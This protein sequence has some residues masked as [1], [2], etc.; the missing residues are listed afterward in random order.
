VYAALRPFAG[1]VAFVGVVAALG[2]PGVEGR[3]L[4]DPVGPS[5]S[6]GVPL[7]LHR[8][9]DTPR[10][11][12]SEANEVI[13]E[14]C[15]RCH[16]DRRRRGNLSLEDFDAGR[17]WASPDVAEA[18]VRKL[19]AGMMPP[20]GSRRPEEAVLQGLAATLESQL[21]SFAVANPNPGVRTFQRLNQAEY[22]N[23]IGD[24]L[25][26]RI[27]AAAYLPSDTKSANFDNIADVQLLSPTLLDAYLN[28]AAEI[29]RLA[30]GDPNAIPE[31]A[32][33]TVPR[34][35]S[36]WEWVEG[37]PFGTR[38]GLSVVHTFPADGNYTFRIRLQPTPTGQLFGR[39]ARD[40]AV[41]ISVDGER[42][43]LIPV[44]RWTSQADPTGM[45]VRVDHTV[46][47]RAGQHRVSAAFLPNFEGPVDDILAPVGHSLAD[48]RIGLA[49]GVTTLPHLRDLVISGPYDATGVSDTPT[50]RRI[51]VC[52]PTAPDEEEPCARRILTRLATRAYRR[53]LRDDDV[54]DLMAFYRDAA[55][56]D[57]FEHGVRMGLQAMLAS[58]HF[59]FRIEDGEGAPDA[60]GLV[61][62]S[63]TDLASRLSFF[64]WG[65]VPDGEL[66]ALAR[67]GRL[68]DADVLEGQV[69][70][71]L[72][73]PAAARLG[74]RFASQWL[75]LSDIEKVHP[76]PLVY[77]DFDQQLAGMMVEETERFF[78][79]LVADDASVLQLLTAD[80]TVVN[81]RLAAH[82]GIPGVAGPEFRRV[83][84]VDPRRR[85]L[86]GQGSILTLTSHANRTSPVLRGKWV[87]EVLMGT[88]PP[89]PPPDVPDLDANEPAVD[90]RFLTVR[91]QME[92][93]RADPS[94][95][96]C[97][98]FI[99]PIGLALENFD[100]VGRWRTRD[101]G[102][103]VDASGELYD[104][105]PLTGPGDLREALMARPEPLL[106]TF[107]ENLM[108]YALGRRV[109]YY[110]MPTVR[111]IVADARDRDYAIS[112]FVLGVVR[113]PAFQMRRTDDP[114]DDAADA[115]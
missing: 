55:A 49:Y 106:R 58:P 94:C 109:E 76:D 87:M 27:D 107:T 68:A 18:M 52:R 43:A 108:A 103:P 54:T 114:T 59:I 110:D 13:E 70:R 8:H 62:L 115:G 1:S 67:D 98:V 104:G 69:R 4:P 77:P 84:H 16:S 19:R 82:Y 40:E 28:G 17:A 11:P 72:A 29:A 113:S 100:V 81:E 75:R 35:A 85:G 21:D 64:L 14:T 78:N 3:S 46:H 33:Y 57:G 37:A 65:S 15:L 74:A 79:A 93:H 60:R 38:G 22:A 90:G 23:A 102:N 71:M 83:T 5:A 50:R 30:V 92:L 80:W 56:E 20:P 97:H 32:T 26:M 45:E 31:E 96:S 86:L 7:A 63:Q 105:T 91:E 89:P 61:R 111:R 66:L 9:I 47:L 36:Q 112:A 24:L 25:G 39:T 48:T 51:F 2:A 73:D 88:P 10:L 34:L 6:P 44:D 99:D 42:V 41:E 53:P 101:A 12:V 95:N